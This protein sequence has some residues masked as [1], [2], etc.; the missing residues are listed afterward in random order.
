MP[1]S[2]TKRVLHIM[3]SYGGGISTFIHNLALEIPKYDV[4][5]DVVTY[6]S[7]PEE[8]RATIRNTGGDVYQINN[9]KDSGWASF[10][11]SFKR[12][13]KLYRYDLIHCHISGYRA[14]A[15]K[16]ILNQLDQGSFVIHAHHYIDD[17]HLNIF[18]RFKHYINQL[19]NNSLSSVYTGCSRQAIA[20]LF[21]YQ[22]T[23]E[24][25]LVIPNSIDGDEF[26]YSQEEWQQLRKLGREAYGLGPDTLVIGQ[27][28][29]LTPLK[30]HRLTLRLAKLAKEEGKR[31]KVLIAGEGDLY[32]EILDSITINNLED[33]VQLIGRVNVRDIFPVLDVLIFPSFTE[34]L[35]TV[36]IESQAAGTPVVMSNTIPLE[37]NLELGLIQ[38]VNLKQSTGD[39]LKKVEEASRTR[40][41]SPQARLAALEKYYYT[42]DQAA[43]LYA[44]IFLGQSKLS[45]RN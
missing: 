23:N 15:Y 1:S 43:R 35:G 2:K 11:K 25:M 28:G 17:A 29:R 6:H 40:K 39:W 38:R 7:V 4:V 24:E 41:V 20:S 37:V 18:Q 13:L 27:I 32:E 45:K 3:S 12:V 19:I 14:L 5:F 33:M 22:L 34:G 10:S 16:F 30:N 21:G 9:P 36:A 31:L 8:F 44:N 42:N 26:L